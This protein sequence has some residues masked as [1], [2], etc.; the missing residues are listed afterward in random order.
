MIMSKELLETVSESASAHDT[1]GSVNAN[2]RGT[3]GLNVAAIEAK[4]KNM[5]PKEK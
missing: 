3:F 2:K 5:N 1:D 4:T